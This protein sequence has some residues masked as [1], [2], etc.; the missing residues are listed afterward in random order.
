MNF[1]MNIR[2]VFLVF[3]MDFEIVCTGVALITAYKTTPELFDLRLVTSLLMAFVVVS[4]VAS[5]PCRRIA[6]T[7]RENGVIPLR[8]VNTAIRLIGNGVRVLSGYWGQRS[9]RRL[10]WR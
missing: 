10:R 1:Q 4:S 6:A 7:T 2:E 8:I 9:L 3:L 5:F